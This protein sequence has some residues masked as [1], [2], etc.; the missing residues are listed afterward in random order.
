MSVLERL[1]NLCH[2]H[3]M[4]IYQLEKETGIAQSTIRKWTTASPNCKAI[5]LIA[6]YFDVSIDFLLG[7]SDNPLSHKGTLSNAGAKLVK[8]VDKYNVT[9]DQAEA[10][11]QILDAVLRNFI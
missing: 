2:E 4:T 7:R 10:L 8:L 6:N 5:S 1:D 9:D 3:N 11:S